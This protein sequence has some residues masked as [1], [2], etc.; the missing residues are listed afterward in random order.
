[1]GCELAGW[2]QNKLSLSRYVR[3]QYLKIIRL[4]D[5]PYKVAKG[6]ALGV[7][8]DFLPLPFISLLVAYVVARVARFNSIAAVSTAAILKPAVFLLFWPLNIFVGKL[9]LGGQPKLDQ[10]QGVP[11]PDNLLRLGDYFKRFI[12]YLKGLGTPFLLG[13]MINSVIS[14]FLV[15]LVVSRLLVIRQKRRLKKK[16]KSI[17]EIVE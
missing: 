15:Y 13:S 8:L 2:R 5:T 10:M 7:A 17:S 1:M 16:F 4:K 6:V 12:E 11:E 9:F 14:A 3:F